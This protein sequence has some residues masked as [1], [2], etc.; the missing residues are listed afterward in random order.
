MAKLL[1]APNRQLRWQ[2]N[3]DVTSKHTRGLATK[4]VDD[5]KRRHAYLDAPVH[6][7]VHGRASA[8]RAREYVVDALIAHLGRL[9]DRNSAVCVVG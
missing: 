8:H 2:L 6:S 4:F 3:D 7:N 1:V 5:L 9:R